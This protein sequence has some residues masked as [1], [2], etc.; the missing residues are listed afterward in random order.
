LYIGYV[1]K[2]GYGYTSFNGFDRLVHRTA[3]EIHFG[4]IPDVLQVLH[5]CKNRNCFAPEHL[6]IGTANDNAKDKK[7]DGTDPSG[8][9]NPMSKISEETALQIIASKVSEDHPDY[10]SLTQRSELFNVSKSLISSIDNGNTWT[11]LTGLVN[12]R[13]SNQVKVE[14]T[15]DYMENSYQ[16][17]LS[18]YEIENEC[19]IYT[20][21]VNPNGYGQFYF[22]GNNIGAHVAMYELYNKTKVLKD[23]Q[24][25]HL[26]HNTTCINP[27]H[28][29]IGSSRDNKLDSLHDDK[30]PVKLKVAQVLEIRERYENGESIDV[31]EKDFNVCI[32]HLVCIIKRKVWTE[33]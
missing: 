31:I 33:I 15:E 13:K 29:S 5:G 32:Q 16:R 6:S 9:R 27:E 3:Y 20:G 12:D 23:I 8:E 11:H 2:E 19:F 30:L 28:L 7:R 18:K 24:V 4:K 21:S 22:N 17:L 14:L 10:K 25:R 1:D 26:C